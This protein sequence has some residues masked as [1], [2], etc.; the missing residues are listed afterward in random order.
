M[1]CIFL[2]IFNDINYIKFL[3]MLLESIYI[4]GNINNN[5]E[6]EIMIYTS[7][8]FMNIIKNSHMFSEKIHFETND[9]YDTI[10]KACKARLNI[11]S[12]SSISKYKKILYLDLDII[13]KSDIHVI[14]NAIEE[15]I[16]YVLEEGSIG[17]N[18][19]K[20]D[21]WGNSLFGDEIENYKGKTAFTSGIILFNNC[22]K[23]KQLFETIKSHM[24]N[25]PHKFNDQPHIVYNAMKYNLYDNQKL[26]LYAVNRDQNVDSNKIIHHFPG[27]PG[28]YEN[29]LTRVSNFFNNIKE[30]TIINCTNKAKEYLHTYLMRIIHNCETKLKDTEM[31]Y[32][33]TKLHRS[34]CSKPN[35]T[36]NLLLNKNI[37]KVLVI[38]FN[39][40]FSILVM[41]LSN[42][43][44]QITCFDRGKHPYTLICYNKLKET[45]G[46]RI[47]IVISDDVNKIASINKGFDLIYI[48]IYDTEDIEDIDTILDFLIVYAY[49]L[50]KPKTIFII[51]N[52]DLQNIKELWDYYVIMYG[53]IPLDIKM[54]ETNYQDIKYVSK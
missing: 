26:K 20:D 54:A 53:L 41:L 23:I 27:G 22:E 49:R 13:I 7:T 6:T 32:H 9:E 31:L 15:D 24:L 45:F 5:P 4:Y 48:D 33:Y 17:S 43:D 36:S 34:I 25:N 28:I 8:Q 50:S 35:N 1:N 38:G 19:Y 37:N 16:L 39:S 46:N 21:Y 42:P 52:Y 14:F 3:F 51:D 18:E 40:G 44:V 2:C 11:F 30:I 10:D 47:N 29:R 12:L